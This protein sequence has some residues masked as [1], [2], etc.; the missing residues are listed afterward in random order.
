MLER[1]KRL[2]TLSCVRLN[3]KLTL[4]TGLVRKSVR[5]MEPLEVALAEGSANI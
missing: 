1:R 4:S 2:R 5:R 3:R